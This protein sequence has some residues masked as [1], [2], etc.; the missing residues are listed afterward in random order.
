MQVVGLPPRLLAQFKTNAPAERAVVAIATM[1][2]PAFRWGQRVLVL[3][4][5]QDPGNVGSLI[6]TAFQFGFTNVCL[7]NHAVGAHHPLVVSGSQGAWFQVHVGTIAADHLRTHLRT[8]HYTIINTDLNAPATLQLSQLP[9]LPRP[10]A[11]ILGAEGNGV[12]VNWRAQTCYNLHVI[13]RDAVLA[14]NVAVTGAV[15]MHS[16]VSETLPRM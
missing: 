5:L 12:S 7:T 3:D 14:L 8:H 10:L 2:P 15:I 1:Q 16:V 11:V 9:Q 13:V 4:G 6:R